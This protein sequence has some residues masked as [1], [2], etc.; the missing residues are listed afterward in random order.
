[1]KK[2]LKIRSIRCGSRNN[3]IRIKKL[4][5][6]KSLL[7]PPK[8]KIGQSFTKQQENI[9][10]TWSSMGILSTR[11]IEIDKVPYDREPLY[12]TSGLA[13]VRLRRGPFSHTGPYKSDLIFGW[14][15]SPNNGRKGTLFDNGFETNFIMWVEK[16]VKRNCFWTFNGSLWYVICVNVFLMKTIEDLRNARRIPFFS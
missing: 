15:F 14:T 3:S 1:M 16:M 13:V 4:K 12:F 11:S 2:F 9:N 8:P 6:Y 10:K 7:P 5:A